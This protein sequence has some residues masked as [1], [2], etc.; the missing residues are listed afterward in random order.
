MWVRGDRRRRL[1]D[2]LVRALPDAVDGIA[3]VGAGTVL[4]AAVTGSRVGLGGG[5]A[6][7]RAPPAV[8][9]QG[10]LVHGLV[11]A[12]HGDGDLSMK[13]ELQPPTWRAK[14]RIRWF[15]WT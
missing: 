7:H 2:L 11:L 13:N 12:G 10:A 14:C 5:C 6:A 8:E 9:A 4:G 1:L 15:R 3:G